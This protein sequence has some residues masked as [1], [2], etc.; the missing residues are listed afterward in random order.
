MQEVK[1]F[2]PEFSGNKMNKKLIQG[3]DGRIFLLEKRYKKAV[4]L[5]QSLYENVPSSQ[6]IL[7]L[8]IAKS[9]A[10]Q[11]AEA[12]ST[13]EA[14]LKENPSD[15]KVRSLLANYYLEKQPKK[16]IPLYEEM[17]LTKPDNIVFLNNLSW[18]NLESNNLDLALKYSA[19]AVKLAPKHPNVLDTRGM[20]LLKA[21]KKAIALKAL[22]SAYKLTKGKDTD[23]VLNYVSVLISN[24]K[25][26]DA[27]SILRHL[28]TKNLN[29]KKKQQVKVLTSLA[30]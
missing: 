13:L 10:K 17:L 24:E 18:L 15:S 5:L 14:F 20:V 12:I 21:G 8:A 19:K 16:A 1:D 28:N 30:I 4:P 29:Q 22:K 11:G 27:L 9:G 3:V 23:I 2:Y 25:N 26:S 6:N 7:L